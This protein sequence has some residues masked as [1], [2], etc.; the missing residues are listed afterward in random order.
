MLVKSMDP[1]GD[2]DDRAALLPLFRTH[3]AEAMPGF[4][5]FG[6]AR[7]RFWAS[8]EPRSTGE[9][10]AVF[11]DASGAEALGA[12]FTM[13]QDDGNRDMVNTSLVVPSAG[14]DSGA[15]ALL[16]DE[17]R[18]LARG[19]GR[20]RV[21]TVAP[22]TTDPS[23]ALTALGGRKVHTSTRSVLDL[24]AIDR[25][26]YAEWAAPSGKNAEY[27][28]VRWIDRCPD[29][30]AASYCEASAAMQDAPLEDLAFEH[31]ELDLDR[32][33]ELER[34]SAEFGVRRH[35][36]AAVDPKGS[37]AGLHIFVTVPDEPR[38]VDVWDTCV[39][40]EH[41]GHGLGLR[42]KAAASLWALEERPGSRWVQTYNNHENEHMLAVNRAMGYRAAEDWYSFEFPAAAPVA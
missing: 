7:L 27:E 19:Q 8:P 5:E 9:V 1:V 36:L 22:S 6:E 14:H 23:A 34:H 28:L 31:P 41:R 29:E 21:V 33:R 37:V 39:T 38:T 42:L 18:R 30:L 4:P 24:S 3:F 20:E 16:L 26:R 25:A 40:R 13:S 32:L 2:A 10:F 15:A 11:P 35:V 12:V 17:V